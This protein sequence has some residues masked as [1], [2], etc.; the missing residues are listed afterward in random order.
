MKRTPLA[1]WVLLG[2]FLNATPAAA[3]AGD[4][5]NARMVWDQG[6]KMLIQQGGSFGRMLR[7][8]TR[9]ILC[10]YEWGGAI[11]VRRSS[12]EGRTWSDGLRVTGYDY[13]T[14]SNPEIIQLQNGW[15]LLT[16]NE[17]PWD[18][19]HP[20]TIKIGFSKD[21][22]RSWGDFRV[23]YTAGTTFGTAC[24][25]PTE[26]QLPSGEIEIFFANE[27]P[28]ATSSDQEVTLLRSYDNGATWSP[29]QRVSYRAGHRDG[30]PVPLVLN[31]G[32]NMV[33]SIE[34]NGLSGPFKPVML[35]TTLANPWPPPYIPAVSPL[36]WSAL[37]T[38]L[39]VD[40]YGGA[41]YIRQFPSGET[42]MSIQSGE[43]RLYENSVEYSRMVV[44][45]GSPVANNF[46]NGSEPF[47]VPAYTAGVWNA[48]FM[49]NAVTV[50]ALSSTSQDGV[51]GLW[52]IDGRLQYQD[53]TV[54]PAV[55]S[56][57]NAASGAAG[58]VAPGEFVSLYGV[59]LGPGTGVAV[60][61]QNDTSGVKV[62]FNGIVASLT[63]VSATQINALVP[64]GVTGN[65]DAVVE[66]KGTKTSPYPLGVTPASPG[67]F[68]K[69]DGSRQAVVVNADG[70]F[71]SPDN[72]APRGSYVAFWATGQGLCDPGTS[73]DGSQRPSFPRPE[74]PVT[75]RVGG[76]D[77]PVAF[78]GLT[79]PGVLQVNIKVPDYSP[80]GAS[81]QL[82]LTIG[83]QSSGAQ[84]TLSV[85]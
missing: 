12:D 79:Y 68:M 52:V 77:A 45:L 14:A 56:V 16:Y 81:V 18:G 61:P 54:I 29:P 60:D 83:S 73:T 5:H 15:L 80:S 31:G 78:A 69:P 76:A 48:L 24:W 46:T 1:A 37:E 70:T 58:P 59:G 36:R 20:Y 21:E 19:V 75:S 82:V 10:S 11:Y 71:N 50:T 85:R 13:G 30:M 3:Q 64:N 66:Y 47:T 35:G 57:V 32:T 39:P 53:G 41:P 17:R 23:V 27:A 6:T 74:L 33:L 49:K 42:V 2:G 40:V 28:F 43:N 67:I 72:P 7:L 51:Q 38:P 65:A 4:Y 22:G 26:I 62:Y 34:D 8:D 84:A 63:Y 44:Y 55:Q 25:E 9:E